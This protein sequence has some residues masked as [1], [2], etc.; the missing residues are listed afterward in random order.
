MF[1]FKKISKESGVFVVCCFVGGVC[2]V[3]EWCLGGR[4]LGA[5]VLL[6]G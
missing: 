6:K 4:V 5:L 1:C 3:L 2:R